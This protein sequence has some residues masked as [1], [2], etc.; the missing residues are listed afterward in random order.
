MLW[1]RKIIFYIFSLLYLIFCPLIVLR[2]LGFDIN[3]LTLRL[4]KTGLIYVSTNPP[5]ATVYI[6]GR[7]ASQKTPTALRDLHPGEHFI[8][9]ELNGYN[10]WERSIPVIGKKATVLANA[11][12]I[13]EEWPIKTI[14]KGPYQNIFIAADNILITTNPILK[15]IDTFHTA[16]G[17]EKN[18]YEKKPLFSANSIY[19]YGKLVRLYNAPQSPFI[20]L[21]ADIKTKHKFLWINLKDNPPVIE[22]ISDLFF[23]IPNL[24]TWDNTDNTNIFAFN[25]KNI[26]RINIKDKAIFHQNANFLP[27]RLNLHYIENQ[28]EQFLINDKNDLLI[29]KGSWIQIYPKENFGDPQMY[30]IA[31]SNPATNM[32]FEEKTGEL[33][34]IDNE[35]RNLCAAQILPYHPILN[36]PIPETLRNE[37]ETKGP[38][39]LQSNGN[40]GS[41]KV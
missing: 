27:K 36:I 28:Q 11:L 23:E 41:N 37:I 32:Y 7:M 35:A 13:P 14:S 24:I 34:Y 17:V 4:V 16:F 3:P 25:P 6:D 39:T 30:K 18:F 8:R 29:R 31:K 33:F 26:Y 21:E 38:T 40:T 20:L 2:M 1:L 10:D 19:A 15:N 5:G 12:L 22:D 9:I